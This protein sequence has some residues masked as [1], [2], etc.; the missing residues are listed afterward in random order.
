VKLSDESCMDDLK[1]IRAVW[2]LLAEGSEKRK[3]S[4][5]VSGSY[6]ICAG[7]DD[8]FVGVKPFPQFQLPRIG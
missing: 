2:R 5:F 4:I 6:V 8:G 7:H 3:T 1:N